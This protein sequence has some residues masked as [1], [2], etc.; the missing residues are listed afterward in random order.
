ML[1]SLFV[2]MRTVLYKALGFL[3]LIGCSLFSG[4]QKKLR[5]DDAPAADHHLTIQFNAV[6][7]ADSLEFGKTYQNLFGERY[8]IKNFKFYICQVDLIN[9]TDGTKY[10]INKDDYFLVNFAEP[11]STR[12]SL[13]AIAHIYDKISFTLGVDSIKNVSGAQ[14]GALDPANGM[15]W[16][17]NSGYIMAKL[18]G[19]SVLS[20]QPNQVF[21]YHIGGFAGA[22]NVVQK[23]SLE[24]PLNQRMEFQPG[25]G[26]LMTIS[27]NAN[28]WFG[29]QNAISISSTPVCT[30]PGVLAKNI[31]SN[32]ANMFEVVN[33]M[34]E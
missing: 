17:W 19:N 25:H 6:V 14:T 29:G 7:D 3:A 31:A 28:A 12:V 4:C 20:N 23:I 16:T 27:A 22:E 30:T 15:F 11:S 13:N 33:I 8:S 21:E 18:E 32:Y 10:R 34:S 5:F 24:F 26:T 2:I 9:T 1:L